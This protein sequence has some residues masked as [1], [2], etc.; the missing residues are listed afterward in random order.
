MIYD[1]FSNL[2]R[3]RNL[4]P[5]IYRALRFLADA[6]PDIAVGRH[7]LGETDYVNI[8]DYET[9]RVNPVGY[10]THRQYI[11]IQY[12]I[13]GSEL[14]AIRQAD[15]IQV[16]T[17]YNDQRDLTLHADDGAWRT[18]LKIGNGYFL[19]L[20]PNDAH[21]PQLCIDQPVA[22]RKAIAKVHV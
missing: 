5:S 1:H 16:T 17:P 11:D 9:L 4:S 20:F 22:L 10:E 12:C 7:S 13:T 2:E 21:M 3:Y 6:K 18:E 19:I 15:T 14:V 8:M